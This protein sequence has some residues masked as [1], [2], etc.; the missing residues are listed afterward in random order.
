MNKK[1][2]IIAWVIF[3]AL[4]LN[5]CSKEDSSSSSLEWSIVKNTSPSIAPNNDEKTSESNWIIQ[6]NGSTIEWNE[7][8]VVENIEPFQ[9]DLSYE[10]ALKGDATMEAASHRI[11]RKTENKVFFTSMYD[12]FKDIKNY[13]GYKKYIQKFPEL[14]PVIYAVRMNDKESYLKFYGF[15]FDK[16]F[17]EKTYIS[18]IKK[19]FGE[20]PEDELKQKFLA[21]LGDHYDTVV[22]NKFAFDSSFWDGPIHI[23]LTKDSIEQAKKNC[24]VSKISWEND[25]SKLECY[26]YAYQYRATSKNNY[27]E[28]VDSVFQKRVCLWFLE[29]SKN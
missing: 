7:E 17:E 3:T 13:E 24:D 12:S 27:C 19:Q 26:D 21:A 14:L 18:D 29:Y 16:V 1:T 11:Y 5:G 25:S 28:E 22:A 10:D 8:V 2:C 23:A 15:I 9:W 6:E 4:F 20:W